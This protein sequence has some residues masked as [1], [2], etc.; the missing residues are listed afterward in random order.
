MKSIFKYIFAVLVVISFS[1][2][3]LLGQS[4]SPDK[5]INYIKKAD[6][7]I[8]MTLPGWII[9]LT[10]N[11][12]IHD[13]DDEDRL[14]IKELTGHIK[15]LRFVISECL[16]NDF[17]TKFNSL[18]NYMVE[19]NYEP[20]VEVVDEGSI[21]HFWASFDGNIIN[22]MVISVLDIDDQSVFLN[23][24]SNIDMDRLQELQFYK[25]WKE[26]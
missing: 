12:A 22:R 14:I 5:F 8:A 23:I 7:S 18:K 15:K 1:I 25:N 4:T 17:K 6:T 16:P 21:V 24:K 20:L 10:G 3:S 19:N 2:S 13:M 11:I 9:K 26:L